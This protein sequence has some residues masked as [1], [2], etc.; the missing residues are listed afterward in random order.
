MRTHNHDKRAVLRKKTSELQDTNSELI[1][2]ELINSEL[3][4]INVK[5]WELIIAT[6]LQFWEKN[7]IISGHKLRIAKYNSEK[8]FKELSVYIPQYWT[9]N[10]KIE[11]K[12]QGFFIRHIIKY[13]GYN[14]K[15]NV[16]WNLRFWE[17]KSFTQN[18][19]NTGVPKL[20][21]GASPTLHLLHVSFSNTYFR[22]WSC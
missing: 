16:K 3:W 14:Q 13:T 2:S 19:Y 8:Y 15:W 4:N 11:I 1:N 9:P 5:L 12:V 21:P 7:I 22:S 20:A 10:H 17:K 18:W 6:N